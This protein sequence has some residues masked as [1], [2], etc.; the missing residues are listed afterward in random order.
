MDTVEVC[1]CTRHAGG[2]AVLMEARLEEKRGQVRERKARLTQGTRSERV[3][4]RVPQPSR[5]AIG[6]QPETRPVGM[7]E[8]DVEREVDREPERNRIAAANASPAAAAPNHDDHARLCRL[9]EDATGESPSRRTHDN[10]RK[11]LAAGTP[12]WWLGLAFNELADNLGVVKHRWPYVSAILS[13]MRD[14]ADCGPV[15]DHDDDFEARKRRFL[16]GPL[17]WVVRHGSERSELPEPQHV[18]ADESKQSL[19]ESVSVWDQPQSEQLGLFGSPAA[20]SPAPMGGEGVST[21]V[22][23]EREGAPGGGAR[24]SMLTPTHE[25]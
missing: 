19:K 6:T 17:G 11:E 2:V 3:P 22:G 14:D 21:D 23:A 15:P 18:G 5:N 8:I 20:I 25:Q 4:D 13:R 12:A 10:I 7:T 9:W 16:G 24:N 1:G